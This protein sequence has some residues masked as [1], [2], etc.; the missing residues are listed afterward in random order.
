M[1]QKKTNKPDECES[2]SSDSGGGAS[3]YMAGSGYG[4]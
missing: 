3:V 1:E 4:D 2:S